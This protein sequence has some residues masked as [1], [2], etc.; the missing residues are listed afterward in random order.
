M[1]RALR[2]WA[3]SYVNSFNWSAEQIFENLTHS[4]D[5]LRYFDSVD[6][7]TEVVR[8]EDMVADPVGETERM[9]GISANT[10]IKDVVT[11]VMKNDS[12]KGTLGKK[13]KPESYVEEVLEDLS[14][15][16]DSS[17]KRENMVQA[18]LIY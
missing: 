14:K 11:D 15:L 16:L 8:Y 13:K 17:G 2:P 7:L 6:R 12:Q 1:T 3:A 5:A 10:R 9:L 18:G 4:Y